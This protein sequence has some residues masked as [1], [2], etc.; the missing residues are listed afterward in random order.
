MFDDCPDFPLPLL[1]SRIKSVQRVLVHLPSPHGLVC[2]FYKT[3]QTSV[4]TSRSVK[5]YS[6]YPK[7]GLFQ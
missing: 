7:I 3:I 4:I 2:G 5:C 6:G 1:K